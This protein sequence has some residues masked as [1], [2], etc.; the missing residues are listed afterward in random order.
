MPQQPRVAVAVSGGRDSAALLHCTL[1]Q[2]RALGVEVWALH[3]HHGL[4][5]EADAWLR[6]VQQQSRR[7][8]AQ[9]DSR[10]LV[11]A[12]A[13]GDSVEA[14]ARAGRYQALAEMALAHGCAL[15]LLAHHRLDQAET[16]L[17][18]AL[19]GAG[20]AGLAAMPQSAIR[21]GLHWVRP[22]LN[23]DARRIEAYVQR[24][25]L[26]V[27]EDP[28]NLDLKFARNR[29]R[30]AVWP[31]LLAGFADAEVSLAAAAGRAQEALALSREAAQADLSGLATAGELRCEAWWQLPPARRR[32]AL[33]AWL[34][35]ACGAAP[36][37]TLLDRLIAE[38]PQTPHGSWPAP[39]GVLRLHRGRLKLMAADG[40]RP[41]SSGHVRTV[42]LSQPGVHVL[43][44]WGGCFHVQ[45]ALGGGVSPGCLVNPLLKAR[46]GGERFR[47]RTGGPSRPLKQH[48][49]AAHTPVWLRRGPLLFSAEG[50]LMFV[51]GLGLDAAFQAP[52]GTEQVVLTWIS[53][54]VG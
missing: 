23:M 50:E 36:P 33:R 29:L 20:E 15:V 28:S 17:L 22:W 46:E 3:V 34:S 8:G 35:E 14:W 40:L 1:R 53:T 9:F 18:Q 7:W 16:W 13:R 38:L 39:G 11:G 19:R 26:K 41:S 12:P 32:N 52:A 2:A 31:A 45:R 42:D 49:Q 27:A 43:P 47:L 37:Q 10:R 24:H 4:Q 5:L 30:H 54:P 25:R 44:D 21:A 51:P 48:F 6:Q